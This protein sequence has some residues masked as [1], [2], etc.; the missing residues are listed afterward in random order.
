MEI[1]FISFK[2]IDEKR[3]KHSKSDNIE[4]IIYNKVD[5]VIEELF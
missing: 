2:L 4:I 3:L 1:N 5:E